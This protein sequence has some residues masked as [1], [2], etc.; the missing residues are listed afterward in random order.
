MEHTYRFPNKQTNKAQKVTREPADRKKKGRN[1]EDSM[2]L[3]ANN[4]C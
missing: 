2:M 1:Q 3:K 4:M